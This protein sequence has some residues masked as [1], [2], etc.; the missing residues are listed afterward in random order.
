MSMPLP[1]G[2]QAVPDESGHSYYWNTVTGEVSWEPPLPPAPAP[3]ETAVNTLGF[4]QARAAPTAD[5][6]A[7]REG[8]PW[9]S[10]GR[11]PTKLYTATP[12]ADSGPCAPPGPT[13]PREPAPG[14]R[15]PP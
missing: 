11:A 3:P 7:G 5:D 9:A 10:V 6:T 8:N 2:W 14:F 15:P 1:P 12:P 13:P 4:M